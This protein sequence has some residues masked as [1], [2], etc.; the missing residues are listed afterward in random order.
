LP[1]MLKG[2]LLIVGLARS[3]RV[4]NEH[5]SFAEKAGS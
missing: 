1:S 5:A 2:R 4:N 3:I